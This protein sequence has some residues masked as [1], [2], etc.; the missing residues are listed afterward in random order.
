L[1]TYSENDIFDHKAADGF[2]KIW[3]LPYRKR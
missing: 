2:I 1:A 3:G